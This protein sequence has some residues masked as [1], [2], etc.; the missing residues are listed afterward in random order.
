[1]KQTVKNNWIKAITALWA[2]LV[3]IDTAGLVDLIPAD[4]V[5]AQW[6]KFGIAFLLIIFGM[7][8]YKKVPV[9]E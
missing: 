9:N 1:M 7:F 3:A 8:G 4:F 2:A 5:G 6:I